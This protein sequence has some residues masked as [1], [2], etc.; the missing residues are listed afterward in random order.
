MPVA[1][2]PDEIGAKI[3]DGKELAKSVRRKI[4]RQ[5]KK[6]TFTPW[7][8]GSPSWRRSRFDRLRQQQGEGL[9]VCW[10]SFGGTSNAGGDTA[11]SGHR[12]DSHA[13]QS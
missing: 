9:S 2:D 1:L 12:A 7:P 3:I 6:L 4:R 5:V 10:L 11:G 13:E 8:C